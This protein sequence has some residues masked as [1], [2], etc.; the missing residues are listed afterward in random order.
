MAGGIIGSI[1]QGTVLLAA[2]GLLGGLHVALDENIPDVFEQK[3]EHSILDQ[4]A[5]V[6]DGSVITGRGKAAPDF[7]EGVLH[8]L[9]TYA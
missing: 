1:G 9:Q 3:F 4:D 8:L 7:A 5:V 6:W 2:A